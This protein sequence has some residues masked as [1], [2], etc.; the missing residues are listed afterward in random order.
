MSKRW[1]FLP[2]TIIAFVT[3][4]F[5]QST[6]VVAT[7]T[8]H[9]DGQTWN[10][11]TVTATFVPGPVGLYNW[12][13]GPIPNTVSGTMNGSGTFTINLPDNTTITPIGSAWRLSI[14]PNA[15]SGCVST[16]ITAAGTSMNLS[17]Q[18]SAVATSPRF[19]ATQLAWAYLDQE[20]SPAPVQGGFYWNVTNQIHRQWS[21]SA[22]QNWSGGG[23]G[24]S[25]PAAPT[26]SIQLSN[27]GQTAF[28]SDSLFTINPATHTA[29]MG[30]NTQQ[31]SLESIPRVI[32]DPMNTNYLGG[33]A[34]AIA[35]TS[36]STPT[37]VIQA[38]LDFGECQFQMGLAPQQMRIILPTGL[39]M[40]IGGLLLWPQQE[41][42]G[43]SLANHPNLQH[44]D[45]TKAMITMHGATDTITCSNS[46]TYTPGQAV[47]ELVRNIAI[48]GMG[49][50]TGT[51]DIGIWMNCLSC[52]VQ[53]ITGFTNGFGE[54]AIFSQG[55]S[56]FMD[57]LGYNGAQLKGCQSFITG[58][59]PVSDS[60]TGNQCGAVEDVNLDSET[61]YVYATDGQ[62]FSSG[63]AA[64]P[65]YPNCAAIIETGSGGHAN[66]LFAQVSDIDIIINGTGMRL[67][68]LRA[69]ATS[70]E[71]ITL[72]GAGDTIS[73][74]T[75]TSPCTDTSLQ[76]AF[77]AGT[78]THCGGIGATGGGFSGGNVVTGITVG[79]APGEFGPSFMQGDVFDS[80]FSP[81]PNTYAL[82]SYIP[83][84]DNLTANS[85]AYATNNAFGGTLF[86]QAVFP[87]SGPISANHATANISGVST[88]QLNTT[89]PLT[90]AW[91]GIPGQYVSIY[92]S[93]GVVGTI[94]PTA[95]DGLAGHQGIITCSG[96][97]ITVSPVQ[98]AQFQVSTNNLAEI[99]CDTQTNFAHLNWP[100]NGTPST[101]AVIDFFGNQQV[102]QV[103][104]NAFNSSNIQLFG[105][106]ASGQYCFEEETI[107]ADLSH[108]VS[109]LVCTTKDLTALTSGEIFVATSPQTVTYNLWLVSN[110][111]GSSVPL[112]KYPAPVGTNW[113]FNIIAA[114]GDGTTPPA[115]SANNT[116][117]IFDPWGVV[118]NTTG[119]TQPVCDSFTRGRLWTLSGGGTA[120]DS[121]QE[122]VLTTGSAYAWVNVTGS[123]G[124]G[125]VGGSGTGGTAAGWT[126]SGSSTTLGNI[127][128]TDNGTLLTATLPWVIS[129]GGPSSGYTVTEG[130]AIS[131]VVASDTFWSDTGVTNGVAGFM[132]NENNTGP[133]SF[134]EIATPGTAGDAVRLAA[135][136]KDIVD[137]GSGPDRTAS[138]TPTFTADAGAG[139][140]P[141]ITFTN[142][143]DSTGWVNVTTGTSPTAAAGIVTIKYA[144]TYSYIAKCHVEAAN[145]AAGGLALAPFVPEATATTAQFVVNGVTGL[146]ASTAYIWYYGCGK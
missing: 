89:T 125:T 133:K 10:N 17:T 109:P 13:G 42:S 127:H 64:G 120:P 87:T 62:Q 20:I 15:T 61:D 92:S 68:D 97:P 86:G 55:T 30:G 16:Q 35:G 78:P 146:A 98:G 111:T 43:E 135:N 51:K 26:N 122:C 1:L 93:I 142:A 82:L 31:Q 57:H 73:N 101:P 11:G 106:T 96:L 91:W 3:S 85:L 12:P 129:T 130:S 115:A 145:T 137:S 63:H 38:A 33:L 9:P 131:G 22:W 118:L 8:D 34:A 100:G 19:P 21:G 39:T 48:G 72:T 121:L 76:S 56:V 25:A 46:Q 18:L 108:T 77:N 66:H 37:Q 103:P 70:R 90:A 6:N 67:S 107:Y 75:I 134:V 59:L 80:V 47:G 52:E 95:W 81:A 69:D 14:C 132:A 110:T 71:G 104:L 74:V 83:N 7:I 40:N 58:T 5:S 126:G 65:C 113:G 139:T 119:N 29:T 123:G 117:M 144:G 143:N 102:R 53:N 112:G 105:G 128:I 94:T 79:T 116:G 138:G 32:Y 2:F 124:G 136:G 36:G 54:E 4:G 84:P 114:G 50:V 141:T 49:P 41:L 27:A 28:I 140:G 88:I 23:G 99:G 24:G 45:A 60:P 44:N